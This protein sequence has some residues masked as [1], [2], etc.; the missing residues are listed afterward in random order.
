MPGTNLT[1]TEARERAAIIQTHHYDVELDLT[2]GPK[3][4]TAATTVTFDATTP[5]KA[6]S[7]I[8]SLIMYEVLNLTANLSTRQSISQIH[9][10]LCQTCSQQTRSWSS[11]I[12]RI[13]TPAKDCIALST[14]WTEKFTSI[15][16]SRFRT[17]AACTRLRT[18]GSQSDVH[19]HC[20]CAS[21]LEGC[22]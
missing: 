11:A 21:T 4:F 2:Q 7:L 8:S 18:A 1:R 20:H 14:P 19:V 6:P 12:R 16:S 17:R 3:I 5:V 15:H 9:A 13:R 10:S 22:E